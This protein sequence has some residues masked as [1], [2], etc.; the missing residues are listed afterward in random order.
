M[1]LKVAHNKLDSGIEVLALAGSLTLGRDAQNFEWTVEELIKNQARRIVID[2]TEISFVDSAGIGI[3]VGCHGKV[4]STGGQLRLAGV[5]ERVLNVFRI[6]KV[7]SILHLDANV[8]ESVRAL[9]A[10]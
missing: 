10:A 6:T 5:A 7:D 4:A 8:G 9:G 3:L 1:P 2:L